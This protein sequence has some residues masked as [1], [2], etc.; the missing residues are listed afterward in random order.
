MCVIS[1]AVNETKVLGCGLISWKPPP[2]NEGLKLS[3]I[4][5]FFD[6]GTYE[7]SASG[8][9]RIQRNI[10]IGRQWTR[11]NNIPDG[12]TVYADIRARDTNGCVGP[13][14]KNLVANST[15]CA[16]GCPPPVPCPGM[17]L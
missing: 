5:R 1:G 14:L 11:V 4:V 15:L 16:D 13:F 8:Y 10:E 12:R 7:T 17:S 3:Y 6:G 2:G 9:R